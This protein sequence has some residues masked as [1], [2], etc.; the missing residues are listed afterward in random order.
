MSTGPQNRGAP[1]RFRDMQE[2]W[3]DMLKQLITQY[4]KD[5]FN[6]DSLALLQNVYYQGAL[7]G[8]VI[9]YEHLDERIAEWSAQGNQA[10]EHDVMKGINA[11]GQGLVNSVK[12]LWEAWD[13]APY[14]VSKQVDKG[15]K[16]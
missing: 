16:H 9:L 1:V 5:E 12:K 15:Y 3:N 4:G 13:D 11:F 2:A 7:A 14:Q 10:T 6:N 8:N